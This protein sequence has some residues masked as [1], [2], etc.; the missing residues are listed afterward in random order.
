MNWFTKALT[1]TIGQK[2]VMSLTGLFLVSFL[3]VHLTG[4]LQLL[5]GDEGEAFNHY[6]L[7]MTTSPLIRVAEIILVL[8]FGLHIYTGLTLAL[9]NSKA[10]GVQY[11]YKKDSKEVSW[12][13]KVMPQ[14]GIVVLAFLILHLI[15]FWAQYKFGKP[16]LDQNGLKDMYAIVVKTFRE[17]VWV[18]VF[19]IISM[20][21]LA[22][23]LNHGFQSAFRTLG[24][25]H[26]KY[27]PLIEAVGML[28]AIL[29]P[30]GFAAIPLYFLISN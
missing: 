10:K 17:E 7:F 28:V 26:R 19:Y 1:S 5:K 13:S 18:S 4:N 15:N 9:K 3:L 27:T 22:F 20:V 14:T 2:V 11:Y 21:L 24:L 8:G 12:F 30:A 29:I 16:E 25:N 23:H 6:T